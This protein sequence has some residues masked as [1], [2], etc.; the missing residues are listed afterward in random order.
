LDWHMSLDEYYDSKLK[1]FSALDHKRTLVINA[2][3]AELMLRTKDFKQKKLYFGQGDV[4]D[5]VVLD[6]HW[7][8]WVEG[9]DKKPFIDVRE[10]M[11]KGK[12]YVLNMMAA[13]CMARALDAP[14]LHV[15]K[16]VYEFRPLP[17]RMEVLGDVDG[18]TFVN[19]S[20][21]TTV[22]STVAAIQQYAPGVI[23]IAGGRA[24]GRLFQAIGSRLAS[25]VQ[26]AVLY[27]EARYRLYDSIEG[28]QTKKTAASFESAVHKA[29][30]MAK[31]GQ[32]IVLSPMCTSF[33]QFD[34]YERR[35][36]SFRTLFN[37]IAASRKPQA[38][39]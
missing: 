5:G 36:E 17:H 6:G 12:Y 10:L 20:K 23:L 3:D 39:S 11:F 28:V 35:G 32:R 29:F 2:D 15:Q 8:C 18:V 25:Y 21:S 7:I 33:D 14:E 9:G 19:D 4:R 24:K 34:S 26:A 13:A 38:A 22:E 27:G 31:P 37:E 30:R 16:A 1:I